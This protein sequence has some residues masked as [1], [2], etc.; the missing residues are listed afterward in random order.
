M[1]IEEQNSNEPQ[2]PQLNIPDVIG[3][4]ILDGEEKDYTKKMLRGDIAI[5]T[6]DMIRI[7]LDYMK[8]NGY[9][10]VYITPLITEMTSKGL[11]FANNYR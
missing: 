9:D 3:S 2:K 8:N 11:E 1:N 4:Y 7:L 10:D 5:L 6:M